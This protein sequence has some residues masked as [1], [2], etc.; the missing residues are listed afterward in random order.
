VTDTAASLIA[1]PCRTCIV[2]LCYTCPVAPTSHV[3]CAPLLVRA[4]GGT[5][6]ANA[7][8]SDALNYRRPELQRS[9]KRYALAVVLSLVGVLLRAALQ[10]IVG[11]EESLMLLIVPVVL[12][13]WLGGFGPGIVATTLSLTLG[14]FL[15]IQPVFSVAITNPRDLT[16]VLLFLVEGVIISAIGRF[17]N[18]PRVLRREQLLRQ[19]SELLDQAHEAMMVWELGGAIRFWN[20]GAEELYGWT[21]GEA[22]GQVSHVLLRTQHPMPLVDFEALLQREQQWTG[23]VMHTTL[24][25]R[26]IITESRLTVVAQDD[27]SALVLETNRDISA[28]QA[29]EAQ[30]Q[31]HSR[32]LQVLADAS[33]A[34]AAAGA[35]YQILLN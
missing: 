19:Q 33:H 9:W 10:P 8:R 5:M 11:F 4:K 29:A 12:S 21:G 30:L 25:G 3:G 34:F 26:Q 1:V 20:R 32:K 24:D 22:I 18:R 28:R 15:F 13:A 2:S 7:R 16:R 27:G 6:P 31:A 35:D 23:E 17:Q 14:T